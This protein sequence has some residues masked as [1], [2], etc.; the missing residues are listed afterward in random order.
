MSF[1]QSLHRPHDGAFRIIKVNSNEQQGFP[2]VGTVHETVSFRRILPYKSAV[3]SG[4]AIANGTHLARSARLV[5]KGIKTKMGLRALL[6]HVR[7]FKLKVL[8]PYFTCNF[9]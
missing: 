5:S 7:I 3:Q 4:G 1:N 9:W 8:F 6:V 2:M